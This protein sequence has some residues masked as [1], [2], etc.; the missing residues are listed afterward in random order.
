VYSFR[1]VLHEKPIGR[2]YLARVSAT[3]G[4]RDRQLDA[5]GAGSAALEIVLAEMRPAYV[6]VHPKMLVTEGDRRQ[7]RVVEAVLGEHK[8]FDDGEDIVYSP[9]PLPG[10]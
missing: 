1:Q 7:A 4:E 9:D 2:G 5:I 3:V 6:V 10:G 8:V